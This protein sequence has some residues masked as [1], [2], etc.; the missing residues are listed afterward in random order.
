MTAILEKRTNM[1]FKNRKKAHNRKL[2]QV[3]K[4]DRVIYE[5]EELDKEPESEGDY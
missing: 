2:F 3:L 1:S 4:A 5:L